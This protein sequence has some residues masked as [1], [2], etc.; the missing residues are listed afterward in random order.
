MLLPFLDLQRVARQ[1]RT[2]CPM[3][4]RRFGRDSR[5]RIPALACLRSFG[6]R[7]KIPLQNIVWKL[8]AV[9][10]RMERMRWHPRARLKYLL[11]L[12]LNHHRTVEARLPLIVDPW[13]A[14]D[15]V[16]VGEDDSATGLPEVRLAAL[17]R[18]VVISGEP[19]HLRSTHRTTVQVHLDSVAA[20]TMLNRMRNQGHPLNLI[21]ISNHSNNPKLIPLL[22]ALV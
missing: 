18:I 11:H 6:W 7:L 13:M 10:R 21:A 17:D 19:R 1:R 9:R 2:T 12:T 4:L 5:H 14:G 15:A 20:L 22:V 3:F 8:A 16:V